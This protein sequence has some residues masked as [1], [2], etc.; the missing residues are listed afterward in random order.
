MS[1][2]IFYTNPQSRGLIVQWMLNECDRADNINYETKVIEYEDI[3]SPEYLAINPMG[4]VPALVVA[5]EGEDNIVITEMVAICTYLADRYP[6]AKLAPTIESPQRG[7]YYR[8]LFWACNVL[9]PAMMVELGR[10]S[11]QDSEEAR[12]AI[13]FGSFSE[14]LQVLEQG[15]EDKE[16]LCADTFTTADLYI[17]AMLDWAKYS[18]AIDA[19]S[20]VLSE[21]ISR[22]TQRESYSMP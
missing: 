17:V 4:K 1:Q 12:R 11:R 16:Y 10:L 7:A 13:G 15:L 19:F 3:K 2:L 14:A 5:Q 18:G 9:E 6:N 20:P 22:I 8:W 21:Y